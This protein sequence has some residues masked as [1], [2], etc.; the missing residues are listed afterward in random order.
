MRLEGL[1]EKKKL[2]RFLIILLMLW[3]RK[4]NIRF[5]NRKTIHQLPSFLQKLFS[6]WSLETYRYNNPELLKVPCPKNFTL[7]LAIDSEFFTGHLPILVRCKT[8]GGVG[9][10]RNLQLGS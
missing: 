4:V 1:G 2:P 8:K 7:P 5:K 3:K 9:L 10:R 6:S